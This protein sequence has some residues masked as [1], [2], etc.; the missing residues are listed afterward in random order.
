MISKAW[1]LS[2]IEDRLQFKAI[3]MGRP[4]TCVFE[5]SYRCNFNCRMCYVRM[6][7]G[8]A[9]PHGR[10]RT[11]D[12]WLDMAR[13]LRDAGVLYLTLSGGECTIFPGFER[14][15]EAVTKMG[16][17]V[18]IMT[19]AGAFTDAVRDV[20]RRYPP[21]NAAIT[22]YGGS[23]ETYAA[24]TGDPHGYDRVLQ[25]I[26]FL[27]SIGV[28]L[29]LN[30]TVIRDNVLDYPKISALSRELGLPFTLITDI[31]GHHY[32]PGASDALSCRLSPAERVMVSACDPADVKKAMAD[33]ADL[34]RELERYK[35]P[36]PIDHPDPDRISPC[37][38][39]STGCAIRWNGD[40]QMCISMGACDPVKPFEIGFE[41]AWAQLKARRQDRLPLPAICQACDMLSECARNCPGRRFE[42]T[43]SPHEPDMYTCQTTWL[44]HLVN[45]RTG[46]RAVAEPTEC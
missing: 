42:G 11:L 4:L 19:N 45:E 43:R 14:L 7:D 9:A 22:L 25:N 13:Q 34:G 33:A 6:T 44:T 18:N 3:Q 40:M 21:C 5:L 32:E 1:D 39:S 15:Y 12:E 8:E 37:I 30:F 46:A 24:V 26:A 28:R 29:K 36:A 35:R 16:F 17:R 10:L 38:G 31:S 20:L 41:A 27:R 23:N 2:K